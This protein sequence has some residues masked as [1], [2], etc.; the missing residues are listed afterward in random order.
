MKKEYRGYTI[1]V[2]PEAGRLV[3]I[4]KNPDG[5]WVGHLDNPEHFDDQDE[6]IE[7]AEGIIDYTIDG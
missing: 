3:S 6:A 5:S 7:H 1:E 4:A 2:L